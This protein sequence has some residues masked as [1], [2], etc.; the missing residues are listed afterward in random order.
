MEV[1]GKTRFLPIIGRPVEEVFSPPA[2][3]RWFRE[4]DVDCR[5][6]AL[7]LASQAVAPF[8]SLVRASPSF[9]GCS[10][11][12][13]CK[14]PAFALVDSLTARARRIGSV[15]TIRRDGD[16]R[17]SGDATD[18][19]AMVEAIKAR[20][21]SIGG[22]SA[23]VLGAGGGAGRAIADALCESG[24]SDLCLLDTD[25]GRLRSAAHSVAGNWPD[26]SISTTRGEAAI[27]INAT[28]LGKADDDRMPF[29][30]DQILG[31]DIVCDVVTRRGDT[32]LIELALEHDRTAISGPDMGT[33]QLGPQLGFLGLK[34]PKRASGMADG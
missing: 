22:N 24:V 30:S 29:E 27:L 25:P 26:V 31:A 11:T 7:D 9:I 14:Q 12:H 3:N 18:G 4:N 8:L 34:P 19:Q 17:L 10:A 20:G 5:M 6:L 13:P 16:G 2:Y 23:F 15:N 28:T 32:R 33:A 21:G 1:T